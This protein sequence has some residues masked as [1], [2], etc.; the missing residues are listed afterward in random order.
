VCKGS[1][2]MKNLKLKKGI[3]VL[4][5]SYVLVSGMAIS[6]DYKPQYEIIEST[7]DYAPFASYEEGN[8]Y[9]G[10]FEYLKE[11]KKFANKKDVLIWDKRYIE[12]SDMVILDS[13]K[14]INQQHRNTILEIMLEYERM[15]PSVWER[16]I[17]SMRNEWEIHNLCY[18]FEYKKNRTTDVDF[19]IGDE[20]K[21]SSKVLSKILGN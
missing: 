16:S 11:V 19:N 1:G 7:D 6:E 10:S 8:V 12:D 5:A 4:V 15:H 18:R 13:Y 17:E 20:E 14:I 21:Y 2:K 9:I 3:L